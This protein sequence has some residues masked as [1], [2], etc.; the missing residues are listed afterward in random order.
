MSARVL[1][2]TS[3]FPQFEGDPRGAFLRA[4]WEARTRAGASVWV[5]A[6]RTAWS[7][8]DL[9]TPLR[10]ERFAYAPRRWSTLTG[11]FGMLENVREHARRAALVPAYLWANRRA[12]GRAIERLAPDL[13]VAHM[14]LPSG[15]IV[16]NVCRRAGLPFEVYGHGTDVD[17]IAHLPRWLRRRFGAHLLAA[18]RVY[19]PSHDK[20]ERL[21]RGL[22]W[23][24]APPHLMVEP[25]THA[26]PRP[27]ARFRRGGGH[28]ILYIGRLIRQKGVDDLLRAA[29]RLPGVAVDVAGD[30]PERATLER[31][32]ARLGVPARFHG[33]VSGDAKWGLFARAALVCVPSRDGRLSEGAPL[34]LEEARLCGVPVVATATGGIPELCAGRADAWLAAPGSPAALAGALARALGAAPLRNAG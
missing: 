14:M 17:V 2:V 20:L 9:D 18:R 32:A 31:L 19:V 10:V 26:T 27:P 33:F 5:L 15:W 29:A 25:M 23:R 1:V 3:T 28:A 13:V 34:V 21:V 22:S 16:A 7:R 8:P 6:P 11:R 24:R 4:H 12:L 30:G